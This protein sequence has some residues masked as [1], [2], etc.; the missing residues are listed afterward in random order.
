MGACAQFSRRYLDYAL[1]TRVSKGRKKHSWL[2]VLQENCEG[3]TPFQGR[4]GLLVRRAGRGAGKA[5][6]GS[7]SCNWAS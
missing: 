1:G 7:W 6:S 2:D 3:V 4:P 5:M